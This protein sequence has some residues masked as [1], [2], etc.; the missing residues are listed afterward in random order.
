MSERKTRQDPPWNTKVHKPAGGSASPP[1]PH[2]EGQHPCLTTLPPSRIEGRP[3]GCPSRKSRPTAR[4]PPA[5]EGGCASLPDPHPWS[6]G[7]ASLPDLRCPSAKLRAGPS[8]SSTSSLRRAQGR[9]HGRPGGCP[10]EIEP[11]RRS[12]RTGVVFDSGYPGVHP[13][14]VCG[15]PFGADSQNVCTL[16]A[17]GTPA[18]QTATRLPFYRHPV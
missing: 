7:S 6:G 2:L 4:W 8:T 14:L 15:R 11:M 9:R 13:A 5:P 12:F 16:A 17:N 18:T 3:G 1:D 10:P